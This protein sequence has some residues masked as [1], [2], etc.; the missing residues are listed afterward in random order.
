MTLPGFFDLQ[1]NGFKGVD[2]S[3]VD[4]SEEG[5]IFAC[6]E[7]LGA[8]TAAFL[9]T[10]TTSPIP[11]YR[12]NLAL[13]AKVM[14]RPEFWGRLP[15][16]HLE[17]PFISRIP[18]AVGA[19]NPDEVK[20]PDVH[21]LR[22]M[23]GWAEGQVKL[24]TLAAEL[25]GADEL[26]RYASQQG[27]TVSIGH[28]LADDA[29]LDFLVRSGARAITHLGNGLPN[30]LH[31]HH[32]F[33]WAGLANDDLIAMLI[34]DGHHLPTAVLKTFFRA[35]GVAKIIVVSDAAPVAG[36]KPG[37]YTTLSN[38]AILEENGLFHNPVKQCLVGSSATMLQCINHLAGLGFTSEEDLIMVG[39][40]NPSR[41]IGLEP[42]S[43]PGTP[44]LF[45]D[46]ATRRFEIL[47]E[48]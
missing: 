31:R 14:Q 24:L 36:L 35:K 22:E 40:T 5:I 23:L 32:N 37:R 48:V 46:P 11:V 29:Q 18:G 8:G 16:I 6:R 17:G 34:S 3:A 4:L 10:V 12:R 39:F 15:G 2:F 38:D 9:P 27:I 7:L 33:I 43:I 45:F 25:P 41:L 20:E 26:A 42:A 30:L 13:L 19:H 21:L 28:S 1:V 44:G 47:R